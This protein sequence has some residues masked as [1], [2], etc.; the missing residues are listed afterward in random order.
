MI[1]MSHAMVVPLCGTDVDGV[2]KVHR[3]QLPTAA[4]GRYR[5][6]TYF[7][8]RMCLIGNPSSFSCA[9]VASIMSGLPHR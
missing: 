8:R 9:K 6:E 2:A 7:S 1:Q 5:E 4:K 3:L